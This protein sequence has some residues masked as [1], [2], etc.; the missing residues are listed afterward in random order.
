M[1]TTLASPVAALTQELDG[2]VRDTVPGRVR[3]DAVADALA[4]HVTCPDLV[5]PEQRFGDPAGY[6]S[7]VLHV[8]DDGAFS[9]VA[10]MWLPGQATPIHDHLS[11]CVVGIHRGEEHE[12]R[13]RLEGDRL[14]VEGIATAGPGTVTG[15]LPPGDIHRVTNTSADLSISLHVYGLDL[16]RRGSSI[17]RR[18]DLPVENSTGQAHARSPAVYVLQHKSTAHPGAGA[19]NRT[20]NLPLTRTRATWAMLFVAG[21]ADRSRVCAV[22]VGHCWEGFGDSPGDRVSRVVRLRPVPA[23]AGP[24]DPM[25]CWPLRSS[26]D[27]CATAT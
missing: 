4:H 23:S 27:S 13:Y 7:H 10:L 14:V 22:C 5:P 21:H 3:V 12:T 25:T 2:A 18:Y 15:L 19:G 17:G 8:A 16:T 20:P 9:L 26:T 11:W 24:C 1:T 6:R